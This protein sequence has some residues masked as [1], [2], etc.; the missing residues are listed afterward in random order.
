MSTL[1][2][3][4]DLAQRFDAPVSTVMKWNRDHQWPHVRVG[5]RI[6]WTEE[7]VAEILRRQTV[8]STEAPSLPGQTRRSATRK[9]AS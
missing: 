6:R 4:E 7:Q 8:T 5:N 2:T 9:R 1:L 3:P